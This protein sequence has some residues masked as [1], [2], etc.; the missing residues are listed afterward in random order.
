MMASMGDGL[1]EV[2]VWWLDVGFG[3]MAACGD[4]GDVVASAVLVALGV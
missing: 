3:S 4:I 2:G 1:V